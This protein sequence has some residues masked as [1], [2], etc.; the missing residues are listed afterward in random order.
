M[1]DIIY[2]S[3]LNLNVRQCCVEYKSNLTPAYAPQI[4]TS[5]CGLSSPAT[6]EL[7][8]YFYEDPKTVIGKAR[9]IELDAGKRADRTER[10]KWSEKELGKPHRLIVSQ[11]Y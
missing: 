5:V 2:V 4:S 1:F 9:S 11:N 10:F 8:C 6:S 3:Y 7:S